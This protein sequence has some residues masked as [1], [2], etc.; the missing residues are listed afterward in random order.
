MFNIF[1]QSRNISCEQVEV[2]DSRA[3]PPVRVVPCAKKRPAPAA[4]MVYCACHHGYEIQEKFALCPLPYAPKFVPLRREPKVRPSDA[5]GARDVS[6]RAHQDHGHRPPGPHDAPQQRTE[7]PRKP[8]PPVGP[9][10]SGHP[11]A[12]RAAAVPRTRRP[13]SRAWLARAGPSTGHARGARRELATGPKD[14]ASASRP[15]S[16]PEGHA[17][18]R[19]VDGMGAAPGAHSPGAF[20]VRS[21]RQSAGN[22]RVPGRTGGDGGVFFPHGATNPSITGLLIST[23]S[24]CMM[25]RSHPSL[26]GGRGTRTR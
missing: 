13:P 7:D 6:P 16:C 24:R 1:L 25:P 21:Y 4:N 12:T 11:R 3:T 9:A 17:A 23:W 26:G 8:G 20:N 15:H 2:N 10:G 18:R 14:G 19:A 5:V 22:S